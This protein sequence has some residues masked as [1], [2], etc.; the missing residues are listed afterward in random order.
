MSEKHVWGV[1]QTN[2]TIAGLIIAIVSGILAPLLISLMYGLVWPPSTFS[3]WVWIWPALILISIIGLLNIVVRIVTTILLKKGIALTLADAILI[4]TVIACGAGFAYPFSFLIGQ[5]TYM[6]YGDP[7]ISNYGRLIPDL[8]VPKGNITLSSGSVDVLAPIYSSESREILLKENNW[9]SLVLRTWSPS[10]IFWISIFFSLALAQ[11]GIAILLRKQWIEEEMLPFPFAQAAVEVMRTTGFRGAWEYRKISKIMLGIGALIGFLIQL[12]NLLVSLRRMSPADVPQLYGQ[13]LVSQY[14]GYDLSQTVGNNV[15]LMITLSPLFL[16][17]AL[18]MPLDILITAVAWFLIMYVILPPI[19]LQLG[20]I[21]LNPTQS[22]HSNYYWI[23]HWYGL[24]PHMITR[25]LAIGFA[26]AWLA[27]TLKRYREIVTIK[28]GYIAIALLAIGI[29]VPTSLLA[30][31][32][33]EAHISLLVVVLTILLYTT[34]MRI[35]AEST[36]IT[37]LYTYGPWWHEFLVLPWLPYR[38]TGNYNSK[39]AFAAASSFYPLVTDRT[40]ATAPGPSVLEGLKLARLSGIR[41]K[42]FIPLIVYAILAGLILG[43]LSTLWGM[44]RYG[45][46]ETPGG[47]W[48]GAPDRSLMPNWVRYMVHYNKIDHMSNDHMMWLPQFII[49]VVL[50][51][52]LIFLRIVIPGIPLN[53]LGILIGDMP[54][55]GVLMF[56]PNI[57]TIVVKTIVIKILGVEGYEKYVVP[58]VAGLIITSF[59]TMW[60]SF[61]APRIIG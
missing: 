14:G 60:F 39:E 9:F 25:G 55:T 58:L 47:T 17:L 24:M 33:V 19:E 7:S 38:L 21:P 13:L 42:I 22:A 12:P 46:S 26:L 3:E 49:G 57:I 59:V 36:W 52:V 51:I 27:L 50:G 56:I 35:R 37:A 20:I 15:A 5:Y 4:Y 41:M 6:V 48:V 10:L 29:I 53:P 34:W 16:G 23:G 30:I 11:I 40:L 2:I 1:S 61:V 28:S 43:S 18:L 31:S 32:G 45:L 54:I 8:W 44:Y